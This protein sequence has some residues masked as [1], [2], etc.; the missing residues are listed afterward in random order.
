MRVSVA[1]QVL[2]LGMFLLFGGAGTARAGEGFDLKSLLSEPGV[3]LVAVD[4][5][6]P[7]CAPCLKALPRWAELRE[8]YRDRG[9]RVVMI[10]QQNV[11]EE[12]GSCSFPPGFSPDIS[13]CDESGEWTERFSVVDLP[14]GFL[15]SWQGSL[16]AEHASIGE[17]ELQVEQWFQSAPRISV[18][19]PVDA[20]GKPVPDGALIRSWVMSELLRQS[21]F[22]LV[23]DDRDRGKMTDEMKKG[24]GLQYEEESRCRVGYQLSANSVLFIKVTENGG[25]RFLELTLGSIERGCYLVTETGELGASEE[26]ARSATAKVAQRFVEHLATDYKKPSQ[27]Q[28]T[29]VK[30]GEREQVRTVIVTG[31]ETRVTE[32]TTGVDL[33]DEEYLLTVV[34]EPTGAMVSVD[35]QSPRSS[36]QARFFLPK[37][38]HTVRVMKEWYEPLDVEVNLTENR[39][40]PVKLEANWG[41]VVVK[42]QPSGA[43]VKVN[44]QT[45]G[46]TPVDIRLAPGGY[47]LEVKKDRYSA[48]SR[49]FNLKKGETLPVDKDLSPEFGL[50]SVSTDP[51]GATVRLDGKEIGRTPL[52]RQELSLGSYVM[53]LRLEGYASVT[54]KGMAIL[55]GEEKKVSEKLNRKMG[56]IRVVARDS[57]GVPLEAEVLL[58]G[59]KVGMAPYKGEV[60]T[61]SHRIVVR[62]GGKEASADVSVL[63]G[64]VSKVE[65]GIG[66]A[67]TPPIEEPK[68]SGSKSRWLPWT[69]TGIGAAGVAAGVAV[70]LLGWMKQDDVSSSDASMTLPEAKDHWSQGN[71]YMTTG[72]IVGGIS[73]ALLTG[74]ILWLVGGGSK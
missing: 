21:K 4:F 14:Q 33:G 62:A 74:G 19:D 22:E 23:A 71:D 12:G 5:W 37:G 13:V 40:V 7:T 63:E 36:E 44:G 11:N 56:G 61:G 35:G 34:T 8:K 68:Q 48:Y 30:E 45:M 58:D 25:K 54:I 49:Q 17:I 64:K 57:K 50:L 31:P 60:G 42:T 51:P 72:W 67:T 41:T 18:A 10:A 26:G 66:I 39:T 1:G 16:L 52:S 53:E 20:E 59:E 65:L 32:R 46:Q 27:R 2:L 70:G 43:T 69:M 24:A 47:L 15:W 9:L 55:P 6:S 3:R 29:E 38:V 73:S 28:K